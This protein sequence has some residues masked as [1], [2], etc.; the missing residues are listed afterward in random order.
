MVFAILSL[1]SLTAISQKRKLIWSDE[2]N[3]NGL[4]D[5]TKWSYDVG[6]HGWGNNE[7]QYYT[8]QQLKN[9]RVEKGML[10]IEAHKEKME[11]T[12]NDAW[13]FDK[14]FHLLLNIAVGG[15]WGG[16]KGVDQK[17]FPQK[18]WIDYVRVYQ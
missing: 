6:G 13:P 17:V 2:F 11:H 12:G 7:L 18:M 16:Q 10:V 4:P 9:A 15:S 5:S 1:I 14:P 8:S 3:K